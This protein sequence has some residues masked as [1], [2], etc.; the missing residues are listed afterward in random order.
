MK[1]DEDVLCLVKMTAAAANDVPFIQK[2]KVPKGSII[3]L[4]KGYVDY[5]QYNMWTKEKIWWVTRMRKSAQYEI[6]E[7]L[8]ISTKEQEKGIQ[9]DAKIMLGHA[10]HNQATRTPS[11]INTL[12]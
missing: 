9:F 6:E 7:V 8:P 5:A 4:D 2:L 10:V 12:L 1:A 11:Q 3:A